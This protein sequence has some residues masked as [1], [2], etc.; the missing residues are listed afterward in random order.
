MY[1]TIYKVEEI[2]G[3]GD[4]HLTYDHTAHIGSKEDYCHKEQTA[5]SFDFFYFEI[6]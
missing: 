3:D 1:L 2:P 6:L 5:I 4:E